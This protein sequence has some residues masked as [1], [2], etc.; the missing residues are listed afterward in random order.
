MHL[1]NEDAPYTSAAEAMRCWPETATAVAAHQ[2][3]DGT[4]EIAA[5]FGMDDLFTLMLR[6]TPRFSGNKHGVYL[7]RVRSKRWLETWPRLRMADDYG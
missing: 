2:T 3:E 5:P 7:D 6:S 1:R 4:Y